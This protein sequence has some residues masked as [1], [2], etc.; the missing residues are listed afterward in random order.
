MAPNP[1]IESTCTVRPF[2]FLLVKKKGKAVKVD[3]T[4][5]RFQ[6]KDES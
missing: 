2:P 4:G 5:M 1:G 6:V 3:R